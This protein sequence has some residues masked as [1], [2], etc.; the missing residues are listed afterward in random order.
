MKDVGGLDFT[1][2]MND[3]KMYEMDLEE[4]EFFSSKKSI[5]LSTAS[6]SGYTPPKA[7]PTESHEEEYYVDDDEDSDIA[8]LVQNIN[9]LVKNISQN[10]FQGRGRGQ[11]GSEYSTE[12]RKTQVSRMS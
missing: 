2:V 6:S 1:A 8:L 12:L 10:K 9:A 5:A 3:L 11:G 4:F 7:M